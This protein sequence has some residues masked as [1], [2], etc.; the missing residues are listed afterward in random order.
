MTYAETREVRTPAVAWGK[1]RDDS[2][3]QA[4]AAAQAHD[5]ENFQLEPSGLWI[6]CD[7]PYATA[8]PVPTDSFSVRAANVVW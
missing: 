5:H 3:P 4:Y 6:S 1:A 8:I 7:V 2:G